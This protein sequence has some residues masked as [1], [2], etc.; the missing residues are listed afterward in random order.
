MRRLSGLHSSLLQGM[1]AGGTLNELGLDLQH[2]ARY[3]RPCGTADLR[4]SM[5]EAPRL[6]FL[7]G[8]GGRRR[9]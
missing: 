2:G 1:R 4:E 7:G 8:A 6:T 3:Y 5:G 9:T